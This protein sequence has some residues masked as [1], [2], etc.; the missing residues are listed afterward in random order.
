MRDDKA[1]FDAAGAAI[2]GVN[3]ASLKSHQS[4]SDKYSF[5]FPILVD[6]DRSMTKA[7]DALKENETSV[8]RTVVG[9]DKKGVIRYYK[10]GM[11]ADDDI[12]QAIRSF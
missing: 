10:Q 1:K 3:P 5:P 6:A 12:L 9:I 7:Y 2:F 8:Q 11:P 4:F